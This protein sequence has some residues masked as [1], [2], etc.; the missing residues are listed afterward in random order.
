M[1][2]S[3]IFAAVLAAVFLLL[4][5]LPISVCIADGNEAEEKMPDSE[6]IRQT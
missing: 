5:I 2:L 6:G 1:S 3:L 4:F